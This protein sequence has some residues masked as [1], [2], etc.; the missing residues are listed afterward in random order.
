MVARTEKTLKD[1]AEGVRAKTGNRVEW[2]TADISTVEGAERVIGY[3]RTGLPQVDVLV[4]NA[5]AT[6]SPLGKGR[7]VFEAEESA[8][9][10]AISTNVLG[11]LRLCK[12]FGKDMIDG[13]GGSI[14]NILSGAGFLPV[15]S[16]S[17]YGT[18]KAALWM[19]TRYLAEEGGP[20]VRA[21]AVCPG[22]IS[23]ESG[24]AVPAH[25]RLLSSVALKRLGVADEVAGAVLYLASPAASYTSGS[26]ITVNGGRPW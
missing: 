5:T 8:W 18:T 1:A 9:E 12:A 26:V 14:I 7:S 10:T 21:N 22:T 20:K 15:P 19:L 23:S 11:P 6:G 24:P 16:L 17:A 13:S 4:N 3:A 2:V 25:E